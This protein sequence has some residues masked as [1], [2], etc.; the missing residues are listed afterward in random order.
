M[1]H[2]DSVQRTRGFPDVELFDL[3]LLSLESASDVQ[4]TDAL[5][6]SEQCGRG[7]KR[8]C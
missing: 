1:T 6:R 5:I 2:W 7:P 3:N 4:V 8:I